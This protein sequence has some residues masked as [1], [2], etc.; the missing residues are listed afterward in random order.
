[1]QQQHPSVVLDHVSFSFDDGTEV[2]HDLSTTFRSGV[3]GIIGPNG[4][5]K[6]VLL[7]LI[8]GELTPDSGTLWRPERIAV[9]PQRLTL[10]A[11]RTLADLLGVQRI[12]DSL[13]ELTYTEA[14]PQRV[15]ELMQVIG[16]DWAAEEEA[17]A[18]LDAVGLGHLADTEAGLSR[19]VETLSGGEAMLLA[20]AGLRRSAPELTLLDEPSNNLDG[21]ARERLREALRGWPGSVLMISHDRTLLRAADAIAEL[22]PRRV[23]AGRA[24]GVILEQFGGGWDDYVARREAAQE[25]ASR[26][27][28]EA[29]SS[30]AKERR[31]RQSAETALARSARQGKEAAKSM[32]KILANTRKN[33]AEGTAGRVR[34]AHAARV[35]QATQ[36][37]DAA[38]ESL[39]EVAAIDVDLPGT[40]LSQGATALLGRVPQLPGTVLVDDGVP[41]PSGAPLTLRGPE[42]VALT[43]PNGSGKSTLLE[44]ILPGAL[45]P[46]GVLHQ[47]TGVVSDGPSLS[48]SDSVLTNL[49]GVV[50]RLVESRARDVLARLGL[51]GERVLEPFGR[52]SGG[53]RFR[54]D[55]AR[56]VAADPPPQLLVLDEPTNDLDLESIQALGLALADYAG[57]IVVVSHDP[58]FR[59]ALG[60]TRTWELR[61]M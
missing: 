57:A 47:R 54:V 51:R 42:V 39:R 32:P 31:T 5:G 8:S 56:V 46:V 52:L 10:Q 3:T 28:R 49:L 48:D 2:F 41:L 7:R 33:A 16:D 25:A 59:E 60:I 11:H 20:L 38:R 61:Q 34:T 26:E 15:A 13:A 53:E 50:P 43:G 58:D 21:A 22:L 17:L 23:R 40:A 6:S 29:Q 35:G 55:L 36:A 24:E 9:L 44:A 18:A 37:L 12:L 27:L 14:T 30:L 19:T 4:L 45:V 1:M